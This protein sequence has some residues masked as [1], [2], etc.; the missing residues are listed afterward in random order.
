MD[1][2]YLSIHILNKSWM[3]WVLQMGS[4][5]MEYTVG[6][7]VQMRKRH[8]MEMA[9]KLIMILFEN[10]FLEGIHCAF[11]PS[12]MCLFLCFLC[13]ML[14]NFAFPNFNFNF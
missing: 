10:F 14:A 8:V 13:K 3:K 12:L 6:I 9:P 4:W 11:N 1:E 5:N 7:D 2:S